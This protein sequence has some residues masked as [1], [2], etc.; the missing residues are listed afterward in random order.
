VRKNHEQHE[1]FPPS[2]ATNIRNSFIIK[3][4]PGEIEYMVEG[5]RDKNKDLLRED[6]VSKLS[7]SESS[8]VKSIFEQK[9]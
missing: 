4:T 3:H 6:I 2:N 7:Q 5:F 1:N 8:V 9:L